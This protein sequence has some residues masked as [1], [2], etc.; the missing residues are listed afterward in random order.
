MFFV[1]LNGL[2]AQKLTDDFHTSKLACLFTQPA[3]LADTLIALF[4]ER[5]AVA[6]VEP[7]Q[8]DRQYKRKISQPVANRSWPLR[9]CRMIHIVSSE[10][11]LEGFLWPEFRRVDFFQAGSIPI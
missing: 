4:A 2:R 5:E 7:D 9:W 6:H 10:D 3:P 11:R 1:L 8:R